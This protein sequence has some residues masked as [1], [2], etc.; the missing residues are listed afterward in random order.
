M[1]WLKSG[2]LALVCA[3][4]LAGLTRL[5]SPAQAQSAPA[6]PQWTPV[7][8]SALTPATEA[9]KGVDGRYHGVYEL[10]LANTSPVAVTVNRIELVDGESPD[11]SIASF[12]DDDL[13]LRLRT[14]GNAPAPS[15][16]LGPSQTRL[17]LVDH[18]FAQGSPLPQRLLH[19]LHIS[20][21]AGPGQ[22][23]PS[24]LSYTAAPLEITPVALVLGPPLR[25]PGWVAANGC[26]FPLVGHRSTGLPTNGEIHFAQRFA[27]DWMQLDRQGRIAEGDLAE[28]SSY[29]SYGAELLAVADG[30][31]IQTRND[32]PE[33]VPPTLPDPTTIDL[34]NVLGN[35]VILDLGNGAYALYAHLQPS[36]VRVTLGE[37]VK[38]GQVLGL[39]GNTGNTSAPH[40]HFHLMDGP[41]LASNGLPYT[42]APM[43]VAGQ[44]PLESVEQFYSLE[45]DWR[46]ALLPQPEPRE[47][48]FP[49]FLTVIDF[50]E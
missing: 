13:L 21:P 34:E 48:Q 2:L 35:N 3:L 32:L 7:I 12:T 39:L 11:G 38:Q 30:T 41:T 1:N 9:V 40:L 42:I 20:A 16:D 24:S 14:L 8:V 4:S 22:T 5:Y 43:A 29:P 26:C 44:I 17:F 27:I 10:T 6:Q 31:V 19:R 50:P 45:G 25:G 23:E 37:S 46:S 47:Q 28:V 36:S 18:S 15:A 49:L 33:Q